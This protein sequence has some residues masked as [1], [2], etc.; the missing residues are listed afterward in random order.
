M[1]SRWTVDDPSRP[2]AVGVAP[3]VRCA[4][5]VKAYGTAAGPPSTT[6]RV[7]R[8]TAR[9]GV[10]NDGMVGEG[11]GPPPTAGWLG[12]A[13]ARVGGPAAGPTPP[14]HPAVNGGPTNRTGARPLRPIAY[15][16]PSNAGRRPRA[17]HAA[18]AG[19]AY[20][21]TSARAAWSTSPLESFCTNA[22]TLSFFSASGRALFGKGCSTAYL[23]R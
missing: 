22:T 4:D 2:A 1:D 15:G 7:G 20:S 5:A 14:P 18:V 12:E 21:A 13:A 8:A 9:R 6:G 10:V 19:A 17:F 23:S 3:A 16:G 11:A